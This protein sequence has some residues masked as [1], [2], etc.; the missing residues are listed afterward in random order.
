M[1]NTGPSFN[2]YGRTDA[3]GRGF[4]KELAKRIRLLIES[5]DLLNEVYGFLETIDGPIE[6]S[7][8]HHADCDACEL[9]KKMDHFKNK[10]TTWWLG[11]GYKRLGWKE[12]NKDIAIWKEVA[13]QI[14]E[15]DHALSHGNLAP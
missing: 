5:V 3:L 8:R 4:H 14:K 6:R 9:R 2:V 13:R 7:R 1:S 11:D 12:L 10:F 15:E